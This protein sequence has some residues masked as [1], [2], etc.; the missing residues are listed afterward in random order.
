MVLHNHLDLYKVLNA[1]ILA[2]YN[3]YIHICTMVV[4]FSFGKFLYASVAFTKTSCLCFF[5][6]KIRVNVF[7]S[8]LHDFF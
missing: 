3:I 6:C 4:V 5:L 7:D 2:K 1:V 8:G